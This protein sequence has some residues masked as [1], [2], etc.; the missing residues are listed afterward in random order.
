MVL[1]HENLAANASAIQQALPMEPAD[2]SLCPLP[3]F[4]AY[5]F[6]VL[7][8]HLT[9]GATLML[10]SSM[11]Y[12]L[13]VLERMRD[14]HVT[15][16]YGVPSTYYVLLERGHLAHATAQGWLDSLRYCAQAGGAMDPERID[17]IRSLLPNIRFH[18]MYGQTEAS[19][20]LT[21]LPSERLNEKRGS[22]GRP[23]AGVTL[24]IR[25]SEDGHALAPGA[26]G[27]VCAQ[28]RNVMLGYWQAPEDTAR[29]LRDGWLWTGDVGHLDADGYL[30]LTGRSREMIKTG[31]H[32][33]SPWEIEQLIQSVP[34]VREA[35]VIAAPDRLLGEVIQ[36]CVQ[37]TEHADQ[38]A[39]RRQIL[40]TCKMRLAP[41]KVPKYVVFIGELPRTAS[42][43]VRKHLLPVHTQTGPSHT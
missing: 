9:L 34:G 28:G 11:M 19:S 17:S 10:E 15:A 24:S 21:T 38:D 43:K 1:S 22:A 27:E 16:F 35:A 7:H 42:G 5:G 32:R 31:A 33:V 36:A 3:F 4:Y 26:N 8:S 39:L 41:Y 23:I 25:S 18:V 2:I 29:I 20:R 12:P 30:Y 14:A 37:S 13:Q 6:S 40:Q